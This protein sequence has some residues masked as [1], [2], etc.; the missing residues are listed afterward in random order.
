MKRGSLI[1]YDD[2]GTIWHESGDA[3]DGGSGG[4]PPHI[5][6]VG[7]PYIETPFG[8]LDNKRV[9]GVNVETKTLITEDII[10][11]ISAEQQQIIDL[12]NQ[13]LL[14]ANNEV[15]GLL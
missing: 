5:Y 10:I 9:I 15:G 1:I 13:M 2:N 4:L 11:P 14:M 7:L 12:E 8:E 3:D 6:P